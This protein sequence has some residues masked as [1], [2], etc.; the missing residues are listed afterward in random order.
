[1][2]VRRIITISALFLIIAGVVAQEPAAEPPHRDKHGTPLPSGAIA[3][4]GFHKFRGR[5][6]LSHLH[7]LPD[8]KHFAAIEYQK[9]NIWNLE[10]NSLREIKPA[11]QQMITRATY[12]GDGKTCVVGGWYIKD[13][14]IEQERNDLHVIDLLNGSST[15]FNPGTP[16][17]VN[18]IALSKNGEHLFGVVGNDWIKW[19][20]SDGQVVLRGKAPVR[21]SS[22]SAISPDDKLYAMAN[23][24]W[25]D[26]V[27]ADCETGKTLHT[28]EHP[29]RVWDLKFSPDGKMLAVATA[30][31]LVFWSP[32]TGEK[33]RTVPGIA[34]G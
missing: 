4:L 21:S 7:L 11:V 10:T 18:T 2:S 34:Y 1:M 23:T 8:R 16:D 12:S 29:D 32:T 19:R 15:P 24:G 13:R 31:S 33:I 22:D 27:V 30:T 5:P 9:V 6:S 17:S 26:V 14:E 28:L 20:V 3:R 25:K